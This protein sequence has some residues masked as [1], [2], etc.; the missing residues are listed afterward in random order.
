V[1]DHLR[2]RG[3]VIDDD[4]APKTKVDNPFDALALVDE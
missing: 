3:Y 1:P 2:A 4:E